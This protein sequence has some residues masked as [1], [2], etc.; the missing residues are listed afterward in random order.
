MTDESAQQW[1]VISAA[2]VLGVYAYRRVTETAADQVTLR[3]L[4]GLGNPAPLGSFVTAWGFT[5]LVVSII[6]TANPPLGGAFALLI[7]T[8]DFLTNAPALFGTSKTAGDITA[9][10]GPSAAAKANAAQGKG[11]A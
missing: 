11:T 1:V 3:E 9:K 5:F 2:V 7:A 6:A 8:S 4:V 10:V